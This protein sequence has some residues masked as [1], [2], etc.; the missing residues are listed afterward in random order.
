[1]ANDIHY[2]FKAADIKSLIDKGAVYIVAS[3]RLEEILCGDKKVITIVVTGEGYT[4][5]YSLVGKVSGCP[6]PPCNPGVASQ[7]K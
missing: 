6:C 7:Y 3:S 2:S 1:M 4:K 5:T